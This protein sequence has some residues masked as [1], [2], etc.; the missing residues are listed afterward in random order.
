MSSSTVDF[1]SADQQCA[2]Y[3]ARVHREK[4]R[5]SADTAALEAFL[6]LQRRYGSDLAL[7]AWVQL[8]GVI[9]VEGARKL[10]VQRCCRFLAKAIAV[11]VFRRVLT[12]PPMLH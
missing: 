5:K 1:R 8:T 12:R 11:S 9:V 2:D 3:I 10:L 4:R 6:A 7:V